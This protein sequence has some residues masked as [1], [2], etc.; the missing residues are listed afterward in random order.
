MKAEH[1]LLLAVSLLPVLADFL[2]DVPMEH[3]PKKRRNRIVQEIRNYDKSIMFGSNLDAMEQQLDI[4][5]AFRQW[6]KHLEA[7]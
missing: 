6:I 7:L 2:E 3:L 1:K 4:Q 5:Q